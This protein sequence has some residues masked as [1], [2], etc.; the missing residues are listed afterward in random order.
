MSDEN[1]DPS[2]AE[3][4]IAALTANAK[5]AQEAAE[6][7]GADKALAFAQAVERLGATLT[8]AGLKIR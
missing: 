7:G 2:P 8:A 3:A 4:V 5:A 1:T 6:L